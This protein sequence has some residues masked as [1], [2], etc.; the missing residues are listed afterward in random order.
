MDF[1]ESKTKINLARAFAG[2][3]MGGARY[4]FIAKEAMSQGY[5]YISDTLKALAKNEMAHARVFYDHLL[6]LSNGKLSNIEISAGYPFEDYELSN[7]LKNAA[8]AEL[9]EA[10][11]IYPTFAKIA[12][13]E[14]FIEVAKSFELISLVEKEHF[15]KLSLMDKKLKAKALYKSKESTRWECS[16]CGHYHEG[17]E[18]W[19]ECPLCSYPQGYVM[20]QV[21]E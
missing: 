4:Q 18:P 11:N 13:D 7:S 5:S 8:G 20:F 9:S 14:G 17:K 21:E 6:E 16:N 1:D 3:C 12:R 2:E 10:K 19:K 15:E